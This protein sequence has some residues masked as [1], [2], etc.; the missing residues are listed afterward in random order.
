MPA[1]IQDLSPTL[2]SYDGLYTRVEGAE[3]V[4]IFRNPEYRDGELVITAERGV[5]FFGAEEY[6]RAILAESQKK[7]GDGLRP[8][9][10]LPPTVGRD[11]LREAK[12][13]IESNSPIA[14][15][16]TLDLTEF[17]F[18][19]ALRA[20]YFDGDVRVRQGNKSS[21]AAGAVLV[22][23]AA[24]RVLLV[25]GALR[26]DLNA[27][28][29]PLALLAR[30]RIV[31]QEISGETHLS[32]AD[33]T[34]CEFAVPHYHVRSDDVSIHAVSRD[35]VFVAATNNRLDLAG[36]GSVPIPDLALYS[37]DLKFFP[38]ESIAAGAS[39][40][41]GL[42]LRTQFG[43]E[44]TDL[45]DGFN[46][47]LGIDGK[48]KGHW[49]ANLDFMSK[50]GVGV[51]GSIEYQTSGA[52]RGETK[53]Y[54][55]NDHGEN[56]G[57]LSDVY[58]ESESLRGQFHTI[59][60]VYAGSPRSWIDLELSYLSDPL[61][62]PEFE[63][64]KF[65]TEKYPET[66]AYYR[67]AGDSLSLSALAK[68]SL[69]EF[70]PI[71]E[72]GVQK[73]GV[74]PS[75]TFAMP[76]IDGRFYQSP[77]L[78]LPVPGGIAGPGAE[79]PLELYYRASADT[80][81]LERH[82]SQAEYNP[83]FTPPPID[84]L[85]QRAA[86]A[87][88]AQ[89]LSLPFSLGVAKFIPYFEARGTAESQSIPTSGLAT[90]LGSSPDNVSQ[91]L[92]TAGAR[93]GTHLEGDAG[94]LRHSIDFNANYRNQFD[95]STPGDEF[96]PFFGIP[97]QNELEVIE[98]DLRNRLSWRDRDTRERLTFADLRITI[99]YYPN[100]ARDNKGN[101]LGVLRPDFRFDFG[102]QFVVPDLRVRFRAQLDPYTFDTNKSDT[103]AIV[104]P[105]G[106]EVDFSL[107]YRQARGDYEA[108]AA[109][110]SVRIGRKWDLD[111]LE[112]YDFQTNES[113]AQRISLRRYEHDW[114]LEVSFTFDTSDNFKSITFSIIPL[115][116][117]GDRPRDRY[118]VPTPTFRGFY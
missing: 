95:A 33:L 83:S 64:S 12:R 57:F 111:V 17:P 106:P 96:I 45:G 48:F 34:T 116:G 99:P 63:P 69:N 40:R 26:F 85:D 35:E 66:V 20:L 53:F 93:I 49:S 5:A 108:F 29:R 4:F 98:F 41:D 9:P 92:G 71:V 15:G 91:F 105:F 77:I 82:F 114:A 75:E 52:Y 25:D 42:F 56:I 39:G 23:V 37:T 103:V 115:L 31:R 86:V 67:T 88:T 55:L 6:T 84:P 47:A 8:G 76:F 113:I 112:Q 81:L 50:R 74:P 16:P 109:G 7:D 97:G 104:S 65:K 101:D 51:G 3:Y 58:K 10:N 1:R 110:A 59:N 2:I 36:P 32:D 68:T 24:G 43:R 18:R 38:I 11:V 72:E 62:L 27:N 61:F 22:D 90:G 13:R 30:A 80:G 79:R 118:V 70:Q 19:A 89:E 21:V 54:A 107:A 44:F 14:R 28:N 102:P 94:S 100:P 73:G 46:Q 60:R 87:T 117:A 78:A